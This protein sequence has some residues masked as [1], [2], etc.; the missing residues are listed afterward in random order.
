MRMVVGR[1][2]V[3]VVLFWLVP[4]DDRR[5]DQIADVL[6]DGDPLVVSHVLE[7]IAD[8]VVYSDIQDGHAAPFVSMYG[9]YDDHRIT[10]I[11]H[12]A[13]D[14]VGLRGDPSGMDGNAA[15]TVS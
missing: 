15:S 14:A 4:G 1:R 9:V 6:T 7:L 12:Y 13:D 10:V 11:Q 5:H 2:L 8:L 3:A